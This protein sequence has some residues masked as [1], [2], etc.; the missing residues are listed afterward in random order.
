VIRIRRGIDPDLIIRLPN[1]HHAAIAMSY[2]DYAAPG[3]SISISI[4]DHL[5]DFLGLCQ[6]AQLIEHIRRMGSHSP[7]IGMQTT[8][9]SEE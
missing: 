6:A 4:T 2:T 3:Y 5:L 1:D 7:I 9:S 8:D